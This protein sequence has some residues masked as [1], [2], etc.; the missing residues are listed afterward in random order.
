LEKNRERIKGEEQKV[1]TEVRKTH[2][3]FKKNPSVT[4]KRGGSNV[5]ERSRGKWGG[6]ESF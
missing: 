5:A 2:F 3:G 1:Q 4:E 6:G